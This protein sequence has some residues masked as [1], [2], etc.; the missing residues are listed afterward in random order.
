MR[1]LN[2]ESNAADGAE[3][4]QTAQAVQPAR[5]NRS[6]GAR[7]DS[8]D[9]SWQRSALV[10]GVGVAL[11]V[12]VGLWSVIV[13]AWWGALS[14]GF[15]FD[16][17]P[18]ISRAEQ[19]IAQLWPS[20]AWLFG[21]Q[22]PLVQLSLAINYAFGGLNPWGYHLFNIVVHACNAVLLC[23][24]VRMSLVRLRERGVIRFPANDA[25]K[26]PAIISDTSI[27]LLIAAVWALHPLTASAVTYVIQRAESMA[28]FGILAASLAILTARAER[29]VVWMAVFAVIFAL[30]SKPTAIAAPCV[31][32]AID[33]WIRQGSMRAAWRAHGATHV[34]TFACL[35][36]LVA[37]GVVDGVLTSDGRLAG[38]GPGV[39]GTDAMQYASQSVRALGLY[40]QHVVWPSELAIDRGVDTL[41]GVWR[42]S[43]GWAVLIGLTWATVAGLLRRAWWTVLPVVF[44]VLLAPTTSFVPLADVAVDHRMY[45]PLAIVV[46]SVV[47]LLI[48]SMSH[49]I[50]SSSRL[51]RALLVLACGGVLSLEVL[52]VAARNRTFAEPIELWSEVVSQSPTHARGFINRAGALLE[53]G[54]DEEAGADLARA[55]TLMPGSPTLLVNLAILDLRSGQAERAM[56]RL[57]IATKGLRADPVVLGARG[58]ALRM[59]GRFDEAARNYMLAA[60]RAPSEPMY[61]LLAGNAWSED[62]ELARAVEAFTIAG[63]RAEACGDVALSASACFNLG[64]VHFKLGAFASAIEAYRAALER[65]PSHANARTWLREAEIREAEIREAESRA[66]GDSTHG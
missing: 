19:S 26:P 23:A 32:L 61:P 28:T 16:D 47:G 6:K 20:S 14:V 64:N 17:L 7:L 9:A 63:S 66:T 36:L 65:D 5:S 35:G 49:V 3:S 55:Q 52:G 62:G 57:E 41:E 8:C 44:V 42:W 48:P 24:V 12:V 31:V 21:S 13:F 45:L 53:A 11:V 38:Y 22:R 29:R 33:V 56:E 18:R 43:I 1:P 54:R 34:M 10:D 50:K 58:D 51:V 4:A 2:D 59:L 30:L 40:A 60:E 46:S 39:A 37:L 15:V 27:S 25:S